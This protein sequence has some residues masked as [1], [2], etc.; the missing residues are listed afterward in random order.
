MGTH[1]AKLFSRE[2]HD[3]TLID[4]SY[5]RLEDVESNFDLLTV[6]A[7][8][9]SI[10]TLRDTDVNRS[11]LFVAVTPDE[12]HNIL[13]C[14]LAKKLGAKQTIAR[15]DNYEYIEEDNSVLFK[16]TGVDHLIYPEEMA[17][18]EM[19]RNLQR[20]WARQWIPIERGELLLI[21]VKLRTGAPILNIP[22]K[23]VCK[24]DTPYHIVA[25][26]RQDDTIIPHGDHCL[27]DQDIVFFMT[28]ERHAEYIRDI[29]GK[30]D[31][32]DV[33]NVFFFG[34][35]ATTERTLAQIPSYMHAKVFETDLE[36]IT[37]L[38]DVV[39]N[40]HVMYINDDGRNI[41]L[42]IEE[43]IE[44]VQAFVATT[45]SSATNVLACLNA[46]KLGVRKT[47]ALI[48]NTNYVTMAQSLDIGSIINIKKLAAGKIFQRMLKADVTSVKS[49]VIANADVAEISVRDKAKVTKHLVR[50]LGL[51]AAITLGGMV[52][53]G[54]AYL[55]NGETQL[56]P[57]DKVVAFC[58][59]GSLKKLERYFH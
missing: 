56:L 40:K 3:I 43:G 4:P 11:D 27:L 9:S 41:D 19:A 10:S 26:K 5:S 6:A 17:G 24:P 21:G 22:L 31:Y 53:N 16:D 28:T 57:G 35:G 36:M 38:Q 13:L 59:D 55:I 18:E 45:E 12:A 58:I 42:L 51:P 46:K 47:V 29:C 8:P 34:G 1:L 44:H 14:T 7:E 49:L 48:D 23:D 33:E 2:N 39:D 20:S 37:H 50:D 32:P 52:R 54:K 25:V 30:T 15:V